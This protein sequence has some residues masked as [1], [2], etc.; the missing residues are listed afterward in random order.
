MGII[1]SL[2]D[3]HEINKINLSSLDHLVSIKQSL[4]GRGKERAS[5]N[6]GKNPLLKDFVE[7]IED[8]VI[9]FFKEI[10]YKFIADYLFCLFIRI[11]R[12][13]LINRNNKRSQYIFYLEIMEVK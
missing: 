10:F 2:K 3:N 9:I 11:Y 6:N 12:N 8:I 4:S 5:K 7:S 13:D 1:I